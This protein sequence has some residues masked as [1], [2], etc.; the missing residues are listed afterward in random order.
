MVKLVRLQHLGVK[1]SVGRSLSRSAVRWEFVRIGDEGGGP[2]GHQM[3]RIHGGNISPARQFMRL[4]SGSVGSDTVRLGVR[5]GLPKR[6]YERHECQSPMKN[7]ESSDVTFSAA[8]VRV[9]RVGSGDKSLEARKV[10]WGC[11]G[12]SFVS[13]SMPTSL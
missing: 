3:D 1:S 7:L 2:S 5:L 6:V 13:P 4:R 11:V 9:W 12:L 8:P 10:R